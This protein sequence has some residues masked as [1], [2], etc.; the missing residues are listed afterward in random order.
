MRLKSSVLALAALILVL[1]PLPEA[2][3]SQIS[4]PANWT[5][6]IPKLSLTNI[7][8]NSKGLIY[9][10][11]EQRFGNGTNGLYESPLYQKLLT[12]DKQNSEFLGRFEVSS[13]SNFSNPKVTKS[14]NN[15]LHNGILRELPIIDNSYREFGIGNGDFIRYSIEVKIKDCATHN[16]YSN[17]IQIND[18]FE[19]GVGLENY[20]KNSEMNFFRVDPLKKIYTENFERILNSAR[21]G[22]RIELNEYEPA[23]EQL[24]E[25]YGFS[26]PSCLTFNRSSRPKTITFLSLPCKFGVFLNSTQT[27]KPAVKD[28]FSG[29]ETE[30]LIVPTLVGTAVAI[31]KD[32]IAAAELKAKQEADAKAAAE[33]KAKQEADAKAAAELKAKQEADAKAAAELKAKQEAKTKAAAVKKMTIT[34]VKGKLIKKV[35]AVKPKCPI[36]Y[37]LKKKPQ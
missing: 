31:D 21:V 29:R 20:I 1:A 5:E 27:Q 6:S 10:S 22:Q 2:T 14:A 35:T 11:W 19:D 28:P 23:F 32:A 15:P 34:C 13:Q 36:G 12:L 30:L 3:A 9:Q 26:N 17:S 7:R 25:F 4:C 16:F 24:L 18:L 33:L 8:V 37:K